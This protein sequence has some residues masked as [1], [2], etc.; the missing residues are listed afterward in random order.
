VKE[1]SRLLKELP[2]RDW[3]G[4]QKIISALVA[5][6]GTDYVAYLEEGLRNHEDADIRNAA[7][8]VYRALGVRALPSLASLVRDEDPEVRLFT[9]NILCEI[10]D[11][12]AVPL[13]IEAIRDCDVNVRCA[14]A[15]ALGN[16][17]DTRA[18]PILREA[19]DDEPW[20]GMAAISSLGEIGGAEAL[21]ILYECLGRRIYPEAA[22]MAIE[23]GG[24][25]ESIKQLISCF[26]DVGLRE[27][28]LRAIIKIAESAGVRPRPEYVLSLVPVLISML[29]SPDEEMKKYAFM[30]LSWSDDI[31]GLSFFLDGIRDEELQE[32]AI[33]GLLGI[34]RKAVCSIVDEMKRS[35]G[36][37]KPMLA[38]VL[39]MIGEPKALLQF[40]ED[41][42]PEVRVEVALAIG[43]LDLE[44][45]GRALRN[46]LSDEH[47]EV[48]LA[49]QRGLSHQR[50][51]E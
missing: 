36:V 13:L 29:D 34:G 27:H 25:Q 1:V 26:S 47:E 39:S 24:V 46:M 8:E 37:H 33:A 12:S 49:A 35:S 9:I 14:A 23:K 7:M 15:E 2:G 51:H 11:T 22:I 42:D 31:A 19:L 6:P 50:R 5:R 18:V 38:K 17:G 48:K 41:E 45:A 28:A 43:S 16:I 21:D 3:W 10:R 44:R 4:R 40:A 30:A 20:V 32:Y